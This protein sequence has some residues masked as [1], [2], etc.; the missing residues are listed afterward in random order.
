MLDKIEE[1]VYDMLRE[2]KPSPSLIYD[3]GEW[4]LPNGADPDI[5]ALNILERVTQEDDLC[6][7]MTPQQFAEWF[8]LE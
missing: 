6:T 4:Y 8:I 5:F 1:S 3:A 7:G 2:G